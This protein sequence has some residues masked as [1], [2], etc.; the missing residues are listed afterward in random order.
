MGAKAGD[1]RLLAERLY[2]IASTKGWAQEAL[3]MNELAQEW[4]KL[5]DMAQG[6]ATTAA[7]GERAQGT[8]F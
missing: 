3:V 5:E 2:L 1:A 6:F 8:L 7:A 4:L